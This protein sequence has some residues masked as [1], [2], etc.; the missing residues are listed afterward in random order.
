MGKDK[1]Q[2]AQ[3]LLNLTLEIIYLLTGEDYIVVKKRTEEGEGRSRNQVPITMSP[4]QSLIHKRDQ[5][6]LDLTNKI[7][8][9]LTG[10]VPLRCQDVTVY[11]SM[12][13]WEYL[14]G[15]KDQ[16]DDI[17]MENHQT[18]TSP[19]ESSE[20]ETPERC[21]SPLYSKN[22]PEENQ[23][24]LQDHQV[25]KMTDIKVEVI[26]EETYESVTQCKEEQIP[27]DLSTDGSS[28][29]NSPERC[30]SPL[31][32]QD[33]PEENQNVPQ[34]YQVKQLS[35]IKDEVIT[36]EEETY[37]G[38]TQPCK[39]EIPTHIR[40]DDRTTKVVVNLNSS[41]DYEVKYHNITEDNHVEHTTTLLTTDTPS[42]LHSRDLSTDPTNHE[43][44]S[45]G[46]SQIVKEV[47]LSKKTS[48]LLTDPL[49]M[50]KDR[51][52]MTERI[53]NLTLEIIYLLTG[54][55]YIVVKKRTEEG[56]GR[57]RNQVPITMSPPQSLIH[58]RDQE[59]LDLTNKITELLTGEVPIRCQDVTVY[60]SMEEWEYIEGHKDQ[61]EDMVPERFLTPISPDNS[62]KEETPERCPKNDPEEKQNVPQDHQVTH[63]TDIKVEDKEMYT[64]V[65]QLGKEKEISTNLSADGST[66]NIVGHLL[67]SPDYEEICNN[68]TEDN[69]GDHSL[70]LHAT[71]T[72]SVLHSRDLFTDPTNHKESSP[73]Q[74]QISKR[75]AGKEQGNKFPCPECGKLFKRKS[76]LSRHERIHRDERP[77]SCSECG[78]SFRQ[79]SD[80]FKHETRHRGEEPFS[81]QEC[82]R[83]FHQKSDL[84]VHQR[85]HT[86]EKPYPCSECG[87]CFI[88]KS[89]LVIHQKIHTGEKPFLCSE[90][91]KCFI[92]KSDVFKHQRTHTGEKPFS[93]SECGKCFT[94]KSSVIAHQRTH[95]G[96]KPYSCPD[97]EKRFRQ[98]SDLLKHRVI[99]TG[100]KPFLCSECGKWFRQKS[101]LVKHLSTHTG[102]KLFS[103]S[104]CEKS[105]S[106]KSYLVKHRMIHT[107]KKPYSCSE[108]GKWFSQKYD[109]IKH[110]RFHT[111][112]KP[113]SCSECGKGFIQKSDLGNHQIIHT[114]EKPYICSECGK[115]YNHRSAL[116]QHKK[117]IHFN[118]NIVA[119]A[120]PQM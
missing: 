104:D 28:N 84:I 99:H 82:G 76:E 70:P 1:N 53:L 19:D 120:L 45:S 67:L 94:R 22:D 34:D 35:D 52:G 106:Q 18:L 114:G 42:V 118:V 36:E 110:Q 3:R 40:H 95:T 116:A 64:S 107:V 6:I 24:V 113:Y 61:Y 77:F 26:T 44:P 87:K 4:P 90:C 10:E 97:C 71:N 111:G 17:I 79:K 109:L 57:S 11:F 39:E 58:K 83:G 68:I 43:E 93:C 37:A 108:C 20:E 73:G 69:C 14:E 9:L 8:E 38:V 15:H 119:N 91:G 85:T 7:T 112:E 117:R 49:R 75:S 88:Q 46:Q 102:E 48:L 27:T 78:K 63:L 16:Y 105:F 60:F 59:I 21:P 74:T 47:F 12:E 41:P 55:D 31:C 25:A 96:E 72:S 13:E 5:D 81:C 65:T 33:Y 86:G 2:M 51:N 66:K 29:R 103:C 56:E 54:E 62:K 98:K 50:D 101:D 115:C 92:R 100:E 30:P 89:V 32:S 23:N 80:L